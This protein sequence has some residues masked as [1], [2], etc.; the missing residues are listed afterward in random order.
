MRVEILIKYH[1]DTYEDFQIKINNKIREYEEEYDDEIIDIDI[2][3]DGKQIV[4]IIKYKN[5]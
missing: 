1:N 3:N 5:K 4:A 2:L